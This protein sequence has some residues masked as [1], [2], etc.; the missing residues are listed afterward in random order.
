M[1]LSRSIPTALTGPCTDGPVRDKVPNAAAL[2]VMRLHAAAPHWLQW[3][4]RSAFAVPGLDDFDKSPAV[5]RALLR[6]SKGHRDAL[7]IRIRVVLHLRRMSTRLSV[8]Q[9]IR[10]PPFPLF[11][12][13]LSQRLRVGLSQ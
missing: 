10:P 3:E 7:H 5:H 8:S 6:L 13:S 1:T 11:L 4:L 9:P 2:D 12:R